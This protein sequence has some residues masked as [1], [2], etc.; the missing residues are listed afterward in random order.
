MSRKSQEITMKHNTAD[1]EMA[2]LTGRKARMVVENI[3]TEDSNNTNNHPT[4]T[5]NTGY[6]ASLWLKYF[7]H[8]ES[9]DEILPSNMNTKRL[10]HSSF[11]Q[12]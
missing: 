1:E 2:P 8:E 4:A 11:Q 12:Q 5:P 7:D 3:V 6:V 9:D 10:S